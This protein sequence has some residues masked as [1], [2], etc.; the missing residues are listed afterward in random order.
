MLK[1]LTV[2]GVLGAA[3][4]AMVPLRAEVIE[5]LVLK[6]NGDIITMS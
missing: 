6:V 5:Q 4:V 3:A 1:K 2:V